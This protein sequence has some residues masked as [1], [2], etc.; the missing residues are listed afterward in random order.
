MPSSILRLRTRVSPLPTLVLPEMFAARN[1]LFSVKERDFT[2]PDTTPPSI[3][4]F[5]PLRYMSLMSRSFQL[6]APDGSSF[7]PGQWLINLNSRPSTS[8]F[9]MRI[10]K[11][12]FFSF[13]SR[14]C[15]EKILLRLVVLPLT[16]SQGS[17]TRAKSPFTTLAW[18][19]NRPFFDSRFLGEKVAVT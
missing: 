14:G 5:L 2:S 1:P 11:E 13:F 16:L 12:P 10:W 15:T 6:I 19:R 9:A 8:T 7:V 17:L 4:R 3:S 18:F